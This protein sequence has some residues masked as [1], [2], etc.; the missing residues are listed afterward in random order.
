MTVTRRLLLALIAGVLAALGYAPWNLWP[1]TILGI[2]ALVALV[3]RAPNMRGGFAVGWTFGVG[4]FFVQQIWIA[5]A[6]TLQEKMPPS[7]GWV[8]V[9][10]LSL[11]LALF[12]GLTTALA[13]LLT[14]TGAAL[15]PGLAATM[16][17]GEWLRGWVLT[18]YPWN[19]LGATWVALPGVAALAAWGGALALTG[20]MTLAGGAVWLLAV[21]A[22]RARVG[23]AAVLV[24]IAVVAL[25]PQA[26]SPAGSTGVLLVVIQPNIGQERR[27]RPELQADHIANL[28]V[29]TKQALARRRDP[30]VPALVMWPE[31]AVLDAIAEEPGLRAQLATALGPRDML[32]T[33]ST[34]TVR[35]PQGQLTA[36]TNSLFAIDATG[37][38]RG[39]YDKA[40]LVP[41]GEYVPAR[42]W[43]EA[44]GLSRLVP[45]D[46]DFAPGPGPRTLHFTGLP[47]VGGVICYEI[48][49]AGAVADRADRPAFLANISNDGWY[50]PT[51]PPAHL[52]QSQ[53]RAIEEGLPVARA[54]PT[55]VSAIVDG[56]GRIVASLPMATRGALIEWLPPALPPTP[57][58]RFGHSTSLAFGLLLALA[59][60]AMRRTERIG[61]MGT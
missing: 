10:G 16:M 49:F 19:P 27:Y 51:G 8:A 14:G 17:L 11:Y 52:A 26:T 13:R 18:G 6:F 39:Q 50:G 23:A 58:A 30:A 5:H 29:L 59:A 42:P 43:M 20:L 36:L 12:T 40:H 22:G 25:I 7:L 32:L 28:V 53:L 35:G 60:A 54:T 9:A 24:T 31:G 41:L 48:I 56:H 21:K 44:I 57:F 61:A 3:A 45:G 38:V 37:A 15:V 2:A 33:G 4:H 1:L 55:G 46:F 47:T 34:G